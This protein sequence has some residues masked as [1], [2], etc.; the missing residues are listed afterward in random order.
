MIVAVNSIR[1]LPDLR[2]RLAAKNDDAL[3]HVSDSSVQPDEFQSPDDEWPDDSKNVTY[4]LFIS[5]VSLD[6]I[7]ADLRSLF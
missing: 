5:S 7:A 4:A 3:V 6:R 2:L 1:V